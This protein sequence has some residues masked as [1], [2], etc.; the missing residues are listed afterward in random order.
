M[1]RQKDSCAS[2]I[3]FRLS[4]PLGKITASGQAVVHP[5]S[6][7][8][9]GDTSFHLLVKNLTRNT[10]CFVGRCNSL[11]LSRY[12]YANRSLSSIITVP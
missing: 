12:R 6:L 5:K 3:G 8:K 9:S 2:E 7:S 11:V 10:I 1:D 4:L